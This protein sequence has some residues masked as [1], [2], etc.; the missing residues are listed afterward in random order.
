MTDKGQSEQIA[1][2]T[3]VPAEQRRDL[4]QARHRPFGPANPN[5]EWLPVSRA[6][7]IAQ[8]GVVGARLPSIYHLHSPAAR[9]QRSRTVWE[10]VD[11]D[12]DSLDACGPGVYPSA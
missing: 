6:R 3:L 11:T 4:G 1:D 7:Q 8:L 9:D 5:R 12:R 10:F 2:F